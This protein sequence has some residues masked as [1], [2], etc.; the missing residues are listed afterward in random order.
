V[1]ANE[2]PDFGASFGVVAP[3]RCPFPR[4]VWRPDQLAYDPARRFPVID[5]IQAQY[6]PTANYDGLILLERN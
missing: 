2:L 1:I 3:T 4:L 5:A 6:Q